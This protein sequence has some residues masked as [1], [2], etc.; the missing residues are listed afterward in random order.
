[1]LQTGQ[2]QLWIHHEVV[3]SKPN[4]SQSHQCTF[5]DVR[6]WYFIIG[7]EKT[8]SF[9]NHQVISSK[10]QQEVLSKKIVAQGGIEVIPSIIGIEFG[11]VPS[12]M[13]RPVNE[14]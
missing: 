14:V 3:N 10:Y 9:H 11:T 6:G 2:W 7:I 4:L 12:L 8:L 5:S 1:M 13:L